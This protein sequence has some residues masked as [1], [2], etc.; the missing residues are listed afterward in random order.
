[1]ALAYVVGQAAGPEN[2]YAVTVD[3]GFRPESAREARDVGRAMRRLGIRHETRTLEWAAGGIPPIQRLEEVARQRRYAELAGVCQERGICAV[4]TGHH[5]G[6]QAETFLFR[7]LRQSGVYGLA[8]MCVQAAFPVAPWADGGP[9]ASGPV[10][11]RPLLTFDKAALYKICR[12]R[13]I[14]W[15]E[16]ASNRDTRIRRNRLREVIA[17]AGADGAKSPFS[18]PALLE[19]CGAMQR[20]RLFVN[21]EVAALLAAH[22]RFRA[23]LGVVELADTAETERRLPRWAWNAA[24]RERVLASIVGWVSCRDHPPELAHL[25]RLEQAIA[26]FYSSEHSQRPGAP[27]VAAGVAMYPPTAGHMW[28]L[29]R[30]PPRPGEIG[31]QTG[32]PL[33]AT[34]LWDG[35]LLVRVCAR[36]GRV[37]AEGLTWS[38]CSLHDAMR[39]WPECIAAQRAALR[40]SDRPLELHRAVQSTLPVVFASTGGGAVVFA[41]GRPMAGSPE[42]AGLDV[43]V[44]A[45]RGTALP[46]AGEVVA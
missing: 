27:V 3:H 46:D 8:G 43:S 36:P 30:Q 24:L 28:L 23:E 26:R 18:A 25:R 41:L 31:P 11:V 1:M 10:V 33:G 42:A 22:A 19:V 45:R 20:H 7:L 12:D 38:V 15:H 13:G 17:A 37:R 9:S 35:R 29:C 32:L 16:D 2:C 34:A 44:R 4:L 39:R 21:R 6:D 14:Q 5:A 40:R